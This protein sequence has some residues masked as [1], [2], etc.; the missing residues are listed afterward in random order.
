[1][2]KQKEKPEKKEEVGPEKPVHTRRSF[3]V[4]P[5]RNRKIYPEPK[6]QGTSEGRK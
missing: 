6:E 3:K 5:G 1:M 4:E 2:K